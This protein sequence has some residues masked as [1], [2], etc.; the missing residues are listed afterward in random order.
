MELHR[1]TF[2]S[3]R[4]ALVEYLTAVDVGLQT[5]NRLVDAWLVQDDFLLV[6]LEGRFD[7]V[8]GNPPCRPENFS[9]EVP[10]SAAVLSRNG[11]G[12]FT[13]MYPTTFETA[14]FGGMLR[15]VCT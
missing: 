9:G 3:T 5:A 14:Y 10:R 12:A 6:P 7:Y 1:D 2:Q 8:V 13:L 11:D 15:H 4:R